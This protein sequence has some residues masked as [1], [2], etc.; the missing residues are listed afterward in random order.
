MGALKFTNR[1]LILFRELYQLP[2]L[3]FVK[4]GEHQQLP[5]SKGFSNAR[6]LILK[7]TVILV[8]CFVKAQRLT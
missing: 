2:E 1:K 4:Q 3:R 8:T 7:K 5:F 6:K